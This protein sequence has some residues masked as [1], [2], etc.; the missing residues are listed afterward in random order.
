MEG[1]PYGDFFEFVTA[2]NDLLPDEIRL[3]DVDHLI[4]TCLEA[5]PV[6]GEF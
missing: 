5:T 2:V 3:G 6:P 4:R 1:E